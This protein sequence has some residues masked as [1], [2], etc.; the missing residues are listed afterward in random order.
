MVL[1]YANSSKTIHD[2]K[3]GIFKAIRDIGRYFYN[4]FMQKFMKRLW[5][6]KQARIGCFYQYR[7]IL[8]FIMELK[9]SFYLKNM[10]FLSSSE[11]FYRQS[12][13]KILQTQFC[14]SF[15]KR[16]NVSIFYK[17]NYILNP[18]DLF[19]LP[20]QAFKIL[21]QMLDS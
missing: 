13:Y 14:W 10:T 5:F 21:G 18:K 6:C 4:L 9:P 1:V 20:K 11:T 2:L 7:R 12:L 15:W 16:L 19:F 17:K 8:H 3:Y